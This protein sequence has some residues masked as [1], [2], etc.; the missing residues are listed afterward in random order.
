MYACVG[1]SSLEKDA[2]H[3]SMLLCLLALMDG[4]LAWMAE[5]LAIN[6]S[7]V[8]I[9]KK[10]NQLIV[11]TPCWSILDH[12]FINAWAGEDLGYMKKTRVSLSFF[13]KRLPRAQCSLC[14]C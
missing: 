9:R 10:N 1:P 12:F 8:A 5:I 13:D 6:T 2:V 11:R 14:C 3:K 4:N 7:I